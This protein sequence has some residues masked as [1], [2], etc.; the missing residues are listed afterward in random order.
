[1]CLNWS[2][3][4]TYLQYMHCNYVS[5]AIT[6]MLICR[7]FSILY[8]TQLF[9]Y[10]SCVLSCK[11]DWKK[12][13]NLT[14]KTVKKKQRHKGQLINMYQLV[15]S[16]FI[17]YFLLLSTRGVLYVFLQDEDKLELSPKLF[18]MSHFSLSLIHQKVRAWG[19]IKCH[20]AQKDMQYVTISLANG[21]TCPYTCIYYWGKPERTPY[22]SEGGCTCIRPYNHTYVL[23]CLKIYFA[24]KFLFQCLVCI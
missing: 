20:Q 13:K 7:S 23:A 3:L 22:K 15:A 6:C 1:M 16:V 19:F 17:H 18:P 8:M 2:F 9:A 21:S 10:L 12:G 14:V 5:I 11:I 4:L 24:H